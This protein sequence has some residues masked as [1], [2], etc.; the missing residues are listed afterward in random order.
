MRGGE[1]PEDDPRYIPEDLVA[2]LREE[3]S[4]L[5]PDMTDAQHAK[6]IFAEHAAAAAS[7]IAHIAIHGSSERVRLDASKYVVERILGRVGDDVGEDDPIQK[8]MQGF[9]EKA[10]KFANAAGADLPPQE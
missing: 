6:K 2:S 8:F 4:A 5:D 3:R 10:E 9:I 7:T 1:L